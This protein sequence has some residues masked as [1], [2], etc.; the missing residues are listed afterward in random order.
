MKFGYGD[1]TVGPTFDDAVCSLLFIDNGKEP[2]ENFVL[3]EPNYAYQPGN[4]EWDEY[5][6]DWYDNE[7]WKNIK[8]AMVYPCDTEQNTAKSIDILNRDIEYLE[9]IKDHLI[10]KLNMN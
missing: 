7:K 10:E 6:R 1:I 4:P 2:N 8:V 9:M 3:G 5:E